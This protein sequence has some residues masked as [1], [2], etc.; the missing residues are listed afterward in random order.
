MI[1]EVRNYKIKPGLRDEFIKLFESR[2]VPVQQSIGIKVFGPLLDLEDP[3]A[4]VF[5]RAFPSMEE[6]EH[7]KARFYEGPIWKDELEAKV[8]PMIDSYSSV[9]AETSPGCVSFDAMTTA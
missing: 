3:N 6:R 9:L 2:A 7:M 5:L 4:F 8:M 1:I